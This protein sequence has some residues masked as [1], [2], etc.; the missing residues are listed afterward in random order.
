M[1]NYLCIKRGRYLSVSSSNGVESGSFTVSDASYHYGIRT[2]G[3]ADG[4]RKNNI[5][6]NTYLAN[7]PIIDK[8]LPNGEVKGQVDP[9]TIVTT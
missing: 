3:W 4:A 9:N 8:I 1:R 5:P 7:I 2:S 6:T